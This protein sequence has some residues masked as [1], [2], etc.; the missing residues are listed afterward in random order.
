M[1]RQSNGFGAIAAKPANKAM[2]I[3]AILEIYL[4]FFAF[5]ARVISSFLKLSAMA[6]QSNGL[7]VIA[8]ACMGVIDVSFKNLLLEITQKLSIPEPKYG[9]TVDSSGQFTAYVD[10]EGFSGCVAGPSKEEAARNCINTLR[11]E[12]GFGVRDT[13]F[14]DAMFFKSL[15]DHLCEQYNALMAKYNT[16]KWDYK[17]LKEC[18]NKTMA[19]R[20]RVSTEHSEIQ[21]H[22]ERIFAIM[23]PVD[24]VVDAPQEGAAPQE[25]IAA[26]S[27]LMLFVLSTSFGLEYVVVA[28]R[29]LALQPIRVSVWVHYFQP[30][31]SSCLPYRQLTISYTPQ[32][33]GVA[34]RKN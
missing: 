15:Y 2:M 12:L 11:D 27:H 1:A 4:A 18:Y 5:G 34:E 9:L 29:K 33:N 16:L 24:M 28:N 22:L 25:G 7:R 30:V 32:Q 31:G 14:E 8:A 26:I 20:D 19:D 17:F 21:Q 13:N 6:W 23:N 3:S 10:V